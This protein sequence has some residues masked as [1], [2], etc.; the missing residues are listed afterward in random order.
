VLPS[1]GRLPT[2]LMNRKHRYKK[3][4]A[5][6]PLS[7]LAGKGVN[8]G[9][10]GGGMMGEN[11]TMATSATA[12]FG[13]K[14]S[15]ND[16]EENARSARCAL[17][18]LTRDFPRPEALMDLVQPHEALLTWITSEDGRLLAVLVYRE[19][20]LVRADEFGRALPDP[21]EVVPVYNI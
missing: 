20:A 5:L 16:P 8:G 1:W 7:K 12:I 9:G 14:T 19:K 11:N 18:L 3:P 15:G 10:G 6:P 4:L 13:E 2:A 21:T 17:H